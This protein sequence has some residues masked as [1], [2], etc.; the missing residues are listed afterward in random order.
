MK[1]EDNKVLKT[2][3]KKIGDLSTKFVMVNTLSDHKKSPHIVNLKKEIKAESQTWEGI[4][5]YETPEKLKQEQYRV[6][7]LSKFVR[8]HNQKVLEKEKLKVAKD[9]VEDLE[10]DWEN[11]VKDQK[12]RRLEDQKIKRS[13]EHKYLTRITYHVT[14]IKN[15]TVLK[16][17]KAKENILEKTKQT[18]NIFTS[19]KFAYGVATVL[20]LAGLPFPALAYYQNIKNTSSRLVE[21]STDAFVALQS[22]TVAALQSNILQAENDLN[23]A[24]NAFGEADDIINKDHQALQYVAKMLPIIGKQISSRE[25]LLSAGHFLALGN[26]YLIKGAD[27]VERNKIMPLTDKLNLFARY[28]NSSIPQ[29]EAALR[30]LSAV[31]SE[32]LPVEYQAS[33][34]DFKVLFA[35][36]IND[37][38]DMVELSKSVDEVFGGEQ[39]KRYLVVFQNN[40][41]IRPTGGFIGSFGILDVQKGKVLNFDI[42][43]GGSYDLKG[44]L[45]TYLKP[46]LPL[47]LSNSRWEFQDANWFPDFKTS[48]KKLEWFYQH[49]RNSTV[50]GV[51]AVNASVLE[52]LLRVLGP[53]ESRSTS[54]TLSSENVLDSLQKK[55]EVDYDKEKNKPK[56][57]LGTLANDFSGQIKNLDKVKVV[58]LLTELNEALVQKEIQLYF[59]DEKLETKIQAFGWSGG[60]FPAVETQDYVMVVN[61]NLQGQK[62]DAKIEQTLEHQAEILTDG[63]VVDTLIIRRV[64]SGTAGEMFYGANNVN[65]LRVYIPEGA[66]LLDAGGFNYPP[67]DAFYVPEKNYL[68]D[69]DLAKVEQEVSIDSKTGTRITNEFGKTAFGNWVITPPGEKSEIY[70]KYKLPFKINME[71]KLTTLESVKNVFG[72]NGS[73]SSKYS[74]VIQKQSGVISDFAT[75]VIYPEG[76]QPA[77]KLNEQMKLAKNGATFAGS[78]VKDEIFGVVMKK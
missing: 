77:W 32:V 31:N 74:L 34:K 3:S 7:D 13:K 24:L 44:Q 73:E 68:D 50:D 61:T 56:E 72:M 30:D 70:F 75:S 35:A 51:I 19:K 78:L 20:I 1:M 8:E 39:F 5:M 23:T 64:H 58:G 42:P 46:P 53:V 41:E 10:Y 67:E 29:Y 47:Q 60:I 65:Y 71:T 14:R 21:K 59:N 26:T 25:N 54:S 2:D 36:F 49:S 9:K 69:I 17:N 38:K 66:E 63:T 33:F 4:K 57:I 48:A 37:M 40:H 43:G 45:D 52:R 6:A 55:V 11:I 27:E 28:L 18:V 62:S 16:Y 22:S 12:I 15:D 76:W